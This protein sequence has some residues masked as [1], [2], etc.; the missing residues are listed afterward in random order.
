[1]L[2]RKAIYYFVCV[3]SGCAIAAGFIAFI[4]L[5]GVFEKLNEHF[6]TGKFSK[7]VETFIV[8]EIDFFVA[9]DSAYVDSTPSDDF[10]LLRS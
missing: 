3:V 1:M 9:I 10:N 8:F 5:I 2:I 7:N 4:T 6:K